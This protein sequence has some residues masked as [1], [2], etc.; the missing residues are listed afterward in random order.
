MAK[1]RDP[2]IIEI[3]KPYIERERKFVPA[4]P[5][6]IVR[7]GEAAVAAYKGQKLIE[8]ADHVRMCRDTFVTADHP[9]L[10]PVI[11]AALHTEQFLPEAERTRP[12]ERIYYVDAE[13]DVKRLSAEF[14]QEA[15]KRDGVKQTIKLAR[16]VTGKNKDKDSSTLNRLEMHAKLTGPGV[17][18]TAVDDAKQRR[19]LT[20]HFRE[21]AMKP[22]FRLVSQRIRIPYHPDGDT[23]I[24]IELACDN[25]LFGETIYGRCWQDPK[26]EIEIIKGPEDEAA[27]RRILEREERRIVEKFDLVAQLESNAELGY[28]RLLPDLSTAG[29]RALL[30]RTGP[31]DV[32]WT[33]TGRAKLGLK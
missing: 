19:W 10:A 31:R 21:R 14:R 9:D 6:H 24:I 26:L 12:R 28:A 15:H 7:Q 16:G 27:C 29:G 4:V 13:L 30:D 8:I 32:W 3:E 2:R 25:I 33:P 11:P 18:L 20:D 17:C 1:K 22:A 5:A 23:S